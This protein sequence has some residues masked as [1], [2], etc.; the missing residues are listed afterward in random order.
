MWGARGGN[1]LP[2]GEP[3]VWAYN[4]PLHTLYHVVLHMRSPKTLRERIF[5]TATRVFIVQHRFTAIVCTCAFAFV[6]FI[7][8]INTEEPTPIA[9]QSTAILTSSGVRSLTLSG[10]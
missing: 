8:G 3:S 7:H 1:R 5:S 4:S 2:E 10:F 6:V 9:S